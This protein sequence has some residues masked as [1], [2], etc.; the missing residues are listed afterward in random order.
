MRY[1]TT[2]VLNASS[3]APAILL[4]RANSVYD[5]EYATG[6]HQPM[7]YDEWMAV[8]NHYCVIGSR[9][10]VEVVQPNI[11]NV[12][13]GVIG[14]ILTPTAATLPSDLSSV[15]E[16]NDT[17]GV[18]LANPFTN[19]RRM[20]FT[21]NYSARKFFGARFSPSNPDFYAKDGAN[22]TEDVFFQVFS[23]GI[24]GNDPGAYT[25]MITIDYIV[26]LTERKLGVQST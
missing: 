10:R 11:T 12:N 8:Y 16:Q 1:F 22:P 2:D 15:V 7:T 19:S 14:V 6:G 20:I 17:R 26:Y 24:S 21:C 25:A 5:P 23:Y 13:P 9:I 4:Y 3:T 18:Q